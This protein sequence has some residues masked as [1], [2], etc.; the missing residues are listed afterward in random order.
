MPW[1]V[2]SWRVLSCNFKSCLVLSGLIWS[3]QFLSRLSLYCIVLSYR[4]LFHSVA[5]CLILSSF[6][7][8]S[9]VLLR[10]VVTGLFLLA[11]R[12][13]FGLVLP[14]ALSPWRVLF[15]LILLCLV[16][17]CIP[18]RPSESSTKLLRLR[19][20]TTIANAWLLTVTRQALK[21]Q[22]LNTSGSTRLAA[23]TICRNNIFPEQTHLAKADLSAARL[24]IL[25][26]LCNPTLRT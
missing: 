18:A 14:C 8:V 9:I 26:R 25:L 7:L 19:I 3:C 1:L 12:T 17:S 6:F 21:E 5:F 10:L 20:S 22:L 13:M 2:S 4:V 24:L 23:E 11:S 16:T 15:Y